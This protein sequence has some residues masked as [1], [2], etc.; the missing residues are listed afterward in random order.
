MINS[1][2]HVRAC[3]IYLSLLSVKKS[4]FVHDLLKTRN[5]LLLGLSVV[6]AHLHDFRI[7]Y[8]GE[9]IL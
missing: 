2:L 6:L 3:E 4:F 5:G 9:Q 7:F 8:K 1:T